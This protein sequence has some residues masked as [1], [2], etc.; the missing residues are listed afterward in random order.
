MAASG[1]VA[2]LAL[3]EGSAAAAGKPVKIAYMSYAV[4]NPYDAPMLAQA[5]AV[6]KAEGATLTV[7][8][9]NN[10][11]STQLNQLQTVI[12]S[13]KYNGIITQPINSLNLITAV[14]SAIRKGIKVVNMDQALG[15]KLTTPD[16]QVKGLSGSVMKVVVTEGHALGT[17]TV[18]ACRAKHLNPCNVGF[19]GNSPGS[20]YDKARDA[21]FNAAIKADPHIKIVETVYGGFTVAQNLQAIQPML[22]AHPYPQINLIAGSDQSIEGAQQVPVDKRVV[23]VGDGGSST[24]IKMTRSGA[25]FGTVFEA[26]A[27]EGKLAA[28]CVIA[29]VRTGKKCGGIN[30]IL[31]YPNSGI[32]TKANVSKFKAQWI[33]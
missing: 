21:G 25:W 4:A 30:P 27:T 32:I 8:D 3:S 16:P 7:F 6:A 18:E 31:K 20:S 2:S 33:G 17:L 14:K 26:P 5:K 19:V 1:L 9:A 28:Q 23:L 13:G 11:P 29:A 15:P 24:G 10:S 22:Q 12:S